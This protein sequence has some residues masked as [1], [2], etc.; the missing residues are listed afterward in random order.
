MLPDSERNIFI[1][2]PFLRY[3]RVFLFS[4]VKFLVIR[5]LRAMYVKCFLKYKVDTRLLYLLRIV[6]I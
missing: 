4:S 2:G 1:T 3:M 5:F 6:Y